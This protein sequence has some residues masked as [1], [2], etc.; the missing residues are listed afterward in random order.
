MAAT[1][2][3][4]SAEAP[5]PGGGVASHV[6]RGLLGLFALLLL[7]S[8]ASHHP[9]D[10]GPFSE[11]Q[12][13]GGVRNWCGA[14]GAFLAGLLQALLGAGG[15]LVAFYAAWEAWPRAGRRWPGR[16]AW[17]ALL[18]AAGALLGWLEAGRP[19]QSLRWGGWWGQALFPPL[20]ASLGPVGLPLVL[21]PLVALALLVLAPV[22]MEAFG[23]LLAR[24][25]G[26]RVWPYLK[27]MPSRVAEAGFRGFLGMVR[28]PFLGWGSQAE[29]VPDLDAGDARSLADLALMEQ[30]REA[31]LKAEM[32]AAELRRKGVVLRAD[33]MLPVIQSMR[34]EPLPPPG[35]LDL[36]PLGAGPA[37]EPPPHEGF[38]SPILAAA[39]PPK[40]PKPTVAQPQVARDRFGREAV[41]QPLPLMEP[42]PAQPLPPLPEPRPEPKAEPRPEPARPVSAKL[43][44]S[45]LDREALPP[46]RLF[47]PPGAHSRMDPAI[48]E[49]QTEAI[50]AKLAEFKIKGTIAGTQPGPVVTVYEFQPDAGIP[51]SRI[52]GMEEDLALALHAEAVR[53]DRIPGRNTVGIEIP[54]P[55]REVI[56]FREVIDAPAFRD[57]GAGLLTLALGKDIAG[58]PVT[59]DLAKMPHLLIGGSTGSGKSV[60]VNAMICSVLLR[61]LPSEAKLILID[62]KMV[63]MGVYE[64]IPHLWAPVVTDMKEAGRVLK[65]VVAQMEDRYRRLALMSV[66]NLEQFNDKI[67]EAGGR[68]DLTGRTPNPRWPER[69]NELEALPYVV[70]VIDELADLM[71]VARAEVEESIARIAQKA[72]AV[73]IHL[74][75][76]TQ[77][78]SVDIITG[79]IKANL[80]SRLSYRVNTKID[81]RTI[82]DGGGGEQLLG[83]G[84]ALFLAPG[85]ARPRRI[86][87]PFLT[88]DETLRLVNWLKERGKPDYNA[89]LIQAMEAEE[90]GGDDDAMGLS[91]GSGDDVWDKAVAVVIREKK[92][93]TSLLQRKLN[94]GYGRAARLIDRMEA[95]GLIGPDR[96]AGKPRE[97]LVD[98]PP[99]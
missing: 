77:R 54:N 10:P 84:D 67:R 29:E 86:H 41:Q 93:S 48:L 35:V 88:E 52:L 27:P 37:P 21:L 69:P 66:R 9:N 61:A 89:A 81:S 87:A 58:H 24:W 18:I 78:P 38:R 65:W 75:L 8:L 57:P 74:V 68:I 60:G 97:V 73:G 80:P 31:L 83:K 40:P 95:E 25:F 72:R 55:K 6:L 42:T 22:L 46:R 63:E 99:L 91:A 51:L 56:T 4:S 92:A 5:A 20:R 11:G 28:R 64:E 45:P 15:Y 34:L 14:V 30:Q 7:L 1:R 39:P 36:Q 23:R 43:D 76:A 96:G 50:L 70:V 79:V 3:E 49:Q 44:P 53:M 59:V 12:V 26:D 90:E 71:M 85:A 33:E 13:S 82:L 19:L 17:L 32:E 62:P 47:D 2:K 16:V 98:A 94:L